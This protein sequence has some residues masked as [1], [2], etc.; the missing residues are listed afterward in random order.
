MVTSNLMRE[1]IQEAIVFDHKCSENREHRH[2][3]ADMW[4]PKG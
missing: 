1:V 3:M 4:R 2:I